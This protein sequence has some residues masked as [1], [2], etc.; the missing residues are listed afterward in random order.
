VR[1]CSTDLQILVT[2]IDHAHAIAHPE[3]LE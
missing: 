1:S 2:D 3:E